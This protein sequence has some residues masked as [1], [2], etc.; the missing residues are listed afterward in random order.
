ME[1]RCY[2]CCVLKMLWEDSVYTRLLVYDAHKLGWSKQ[3]L[4]ICKKSYS[5]L[6][7]MTT[8]AQCH[9]QVRTTSQ[10]MSSEVYCS[11]SIFLKSSC[12]FLCLPWFEELAAWSAEALVLGPT[13]FKTGADLRACPNPALGREAAARGTKSPPVLDGGA[14]GHATAPSRPSSESCSV[15]P[16][17]T[18]GSVRRRSFPASYRSN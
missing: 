5:I 6:Q 11:P 8:S 15:F 10:S 7:I 9:L 1:G 4:S 13:A 16:L 14:I 3:G 12:L 2:N 18:M 17:K